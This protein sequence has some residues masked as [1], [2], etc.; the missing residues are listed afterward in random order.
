MDQRTAGQAE[1]RRLVD[2]KDF[3]DNFRNQPT[4]KDTNIK[5]NQPGVSVPRMERRWLVSTG[6]AYFLLH[7]YVSHAQQLNSAIF[8]ETSSKD[9]RNILDS[10][11]ML[12]RE[13]CASEDVEVVTVY[14]CIETKG[15]AKTRMNSFRCK[16]PR[17]K[18][19]T[20]LQKRTAA[21]HLQGVQA[22]ADQFSIFNILLQ[23]TDTTKGLD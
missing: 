13:M 23:Y 10:L 5:K 15:K 4:E 18:S 8:M 21:L 3:R 16:R 17:W 14:W 12:A 19:E 9:G 11:V 7:F 20:I 1:G 6:G 2:L 22:F